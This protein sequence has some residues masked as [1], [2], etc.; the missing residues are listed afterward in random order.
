MSNNCSIL[1]AIVLERIIFCH[2][3]DSRYII[4]LVNDSSNGHSR[5]F[6]IGFD[7]KLTEMFQVLKEFQ[8]FGCT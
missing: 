7:A 4:F 5:I 6:T 8:N 1:V 3:A 2:R